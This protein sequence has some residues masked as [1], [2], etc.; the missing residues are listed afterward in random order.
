MDLKLKKAA[1][2]SQKKRPEYLTVIRVAAAVILI[3]LSVTLK[4]DSLIRN[5]LLLAAMLIAG[6][7]II[8]S[9]VNEIAKKNYFAYD[10]LILVAAT[11][12]FAAGAQL[13]AAILVVVYKLC[14]FMLDF[15]ISNAK[16]TGTDYIP[17]EKTGEIEFLKQIIGSDEAG[18]TSVAEK[19]APL[20][21]LFA[22]AVVLVG[23]LYAIAMPLI[24][25]ITYS[26]SIKRGLMLML[27]ASPL[28]VLASMPISSII[29]ICHSAACGVFIKDG[30]TFEMMAKPRYVIIDKTGVVTASSPELI[31]F[32]SPV[33]DNETFLK[34]AA[35]VAYNSAQSI[36]AP[37]LR[38]FKGELRPEIIESF[39][40]LPGNGMEITV[41]GAN[42]LSICL[43]T[44]EILDAKHIEIPA[45]QEMGGT[46][47]YL[48]VAGRYCGGMQFIEEIDVQAE[49]AVADLKAVTGAKVALLTDDNNFRSEALAK[50]LG[51][52]DYICECDLE[53][54]YNSVKHTASK[55]R[56]SD[57][58]MFV[59][60]EELE[61]HSHADIDAKVGMSSEGADILITGCGKGS[62]PLS[63]L[64]YA[65][66]ASRRTSKIQKENIIFAILVKLVLIILAFAGI[67]TIWFIVLADMVAALL[68]VINTSR[69]SDV[70]VITKVFNR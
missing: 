29:G 2:P 37:I 51:V 20:L 25:N 8:I 40:E 6:F 62:L 42:D 12:G 43:S 21:D 30:S 47:L 57:V 48:T 69:I 45:S 61:Y 70:S 17:E 66:S 15:L 5:L 56:E 34:L 7:D 38:A 28:S 68:T 32:T 1:K 44:K 64:S 16:E 11:A 63:S 49:E 24:S 55:L 33:F 67:A 3:I 35:H 10:I 36:A 54:K 22:K 41:A 60:A 14:S 4:L 50:E 31:S 19:L 27:V 18:K 53:K 59:S 52:K 65:C 39:K 9:S 26:M 46:V 58:L 13:E 23:V